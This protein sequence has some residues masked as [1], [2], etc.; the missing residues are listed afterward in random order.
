MK[1]DISRD[2][3]I[4]H[5]TL[6]NTNG[7][8]V[9][10]VSAGASLMA[11]YVPDRN[12]NFRN[13]VLGL[14]KPEDYMTNPNYEGATVGPN[15]GRLENAH[16]TIA[17]KEYS[18][19]PNEGRHN[20][21][22]GNHNLSH[23]NWD[24]LG[25][26]PEGDGIKTSYETTLADGT[27]GFPGNRTFYADYVL[28]EN[29]VLE[30]RYSAKTD[31]ETYVNMTNHA[32]YNLSGDFNSDIY[33]H[34]LKIH[35]DHV[36]LADEDR[37]SKQEADLSGTCFDFRKETCIGA[38]KKSAAKL[39][40]QLEK[41]DGYNHAFI[42]DKGKKSLTLSHEASGRKLDIETTS[43]AVV[44]YDGYYLGDERCVS[45]GAI[46]LECEDVPNSPNLNWIKTHFLKPGEKYQNNIRLC[47]GVI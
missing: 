27:D 23:I 35:S 9:E 38:L 2:N 46:A 3:E 32:Y 8:R 6:E 5:V 33:D 41:D 26:F 12:G 13:V 29:N 24:F 31:R 21:H 28:H 40:A 30:I 10:T 45:H 19:T 11:A 1:Y 39:S 14:E 16:I 42:F 7:M 37:I 34:S 47:F 44:V 20:I 15:G 43:E 36:V 25:V 18:L 17:G 4:V 22:G